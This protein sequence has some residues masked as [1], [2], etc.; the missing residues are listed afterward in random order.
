LRRERHRHSASDVAPREVVDV[1]VLGDD[2]AFP[3]SLDTAVD[4]AVQLENDGPLLERQLRRVGVRQVDEPTGPVRADVTELAPVR[5]R[6]DVRHDIKFLT[7]LEEGRLE[8]EVVARGYE[9]L[10]RNT[11]LA[12]H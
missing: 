11:T 5:P 9:Q 2:E 12:Q 7:G 6:S 8:G 4:L 1:V 10:M 3:L